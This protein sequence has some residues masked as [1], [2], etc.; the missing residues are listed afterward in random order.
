MHSDYVLNAV[1]SEIGNPRRRRSKYKARMS[2]RDTRDGLRRRGIRARV[3]L[4][5]KGAPRR[6]SGPRRRR[7]KLLAPIMT[8]EAWATLAS[9]GGEAAFDKK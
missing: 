3:T 1:R 4:L 8:I 6:R 5:L 9:R 2:A 7:P